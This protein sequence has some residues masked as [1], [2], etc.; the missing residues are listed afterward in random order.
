MRNHKPL[1]L[2]GLIEIARR[3]GVRRPVVSTWRSRYTDF[4]RPVADLEVGPVFWWP[5]VERWLLATDRQSDQ[6]RLDIWP[7]DQ[8]ERPENPIAQQIQRRKEAR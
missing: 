2:A 6:N 5:D 4:P 8:P 1:P 7:A 3:A